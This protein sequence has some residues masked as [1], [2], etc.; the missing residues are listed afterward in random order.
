MD[1]VTCVYLNPKTY[2]YWIV[3]DRIYDVDRGGKTKR[4]YLFERLGNAPSSISQVQL[5][6]LSL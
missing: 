4:H 2:A 5:M 6:L 3:N 1:G